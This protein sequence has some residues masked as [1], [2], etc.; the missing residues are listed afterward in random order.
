M[1]SSCNML[2]ERLIPRALFGG[3]LE[4]DIPI[5]FEDISDFR[6]VPDHQEVW[7]DASLDQSLVLEIVEHQAVSDQDCM[8]LY[9]KD[10]AQQ[11]QAISYQIQ[12]K[13]KP[14]AV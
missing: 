1:P 7:T 12:S 13:R 6:P 5:R 4:M 2:E 14:S 9:F 10:L 11:N 3:A 8:E